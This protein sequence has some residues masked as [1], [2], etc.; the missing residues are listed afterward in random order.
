[1]TKNEIPLWLAP[2]ILLVWFGY[3][4][5]MLYFIFKLAALIL[6]KDDE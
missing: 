4:G 3:V 1:M 5:M 2:V 6:G